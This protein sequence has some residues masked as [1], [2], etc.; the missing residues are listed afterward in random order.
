MLCLKVCEFASQQET[1]TKVVLFHK[2][3]SPSVY[4]FCHTM[5]FDSTCMYLENG[6]MYFVKQTWV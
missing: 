3:D 2:L 6:N 1:Q 5:M 4:P